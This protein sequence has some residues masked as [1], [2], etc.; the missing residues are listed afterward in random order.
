MNRTPDLDSTNVSPEGTRSL[1]TALLIDDD[2]KI[3]QRLGDEFVHRGLSV[4]I[5]TTVDDAIIA[6]GT[7][8]FDIVVT[9]LRIGE[10]SG[11]EIVSLARE[12]S[13]S[14][15][16]LVL[17]GYGHI[18]AVVA[19]VKHG[20]TEVLSKPADAGE[21]LEVLGINSL[22]AEARITSADYVRWEHITSVYAETGNNV[23]ATARLLRM[24]RRSLQRLL[25]RGPPQ[26]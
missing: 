7:R 10:G 15:K 22:D 18:N 2:I 14:T 5:C 12:I 16:S 20:A 13:P 25:S 4:E 11:L 23:S 3:V 19:A 17:T 26:R 1:L 9:E 21:I 24:H 8:H 6:L